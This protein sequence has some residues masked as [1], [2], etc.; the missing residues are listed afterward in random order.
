MIQGLGHVFGIKDTLLQC[1]RS[2]LS[3]SFQVFFHV[4]NIL[5]NSIVNNTS[6]LELDMDMKLCTQA[7]N[8]YFFTSSNTF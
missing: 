2:Y 6:L 3:D 8:I 7:K 1:F 5:Q 4:N